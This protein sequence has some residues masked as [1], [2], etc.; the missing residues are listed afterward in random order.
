MHENVRQRR[1]FAFSEYGLQSKY[2]TADN[3][4]ILIECPVVSVLQQYCFTL[5]Q[6]RIYQNF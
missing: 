2:Y 4:N 3:W 5:I 1:T 6:K